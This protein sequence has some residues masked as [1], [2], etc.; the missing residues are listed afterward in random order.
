MPV[1]I[2][3]CVLDQFENHLCRPLQYKRLNIGISKELFLCEFIPWIDNGIGALIT[4][5]GDFLKNGR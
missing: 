1:K 2:P 5:F 4:C 3:D